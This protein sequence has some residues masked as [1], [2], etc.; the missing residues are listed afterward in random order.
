MKA[1]EKRAAYLLRSSG[2]GDAFDLQEQFKKLNDEEKL[3]LVNTVRNSGF[4]P[5]GFED[6]AREER[7]IDYV[8]T[9]LDGY[10]T[11][12][13]TAKQTVELIHASTFQGK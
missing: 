10:S 9:I 2:S 5:K 7:R 12:V 8:R 6:D 13:Y 1:I 3:R 11:R 4:S